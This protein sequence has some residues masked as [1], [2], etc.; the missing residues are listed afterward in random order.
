MFDPWPIYSRYPYQFK[1]LEDLHL[2]ERI[3]QFLQICNHNCSLKRIS[4]ARYRTFLIVINFSILLSPNYAENGWN[5]S[6]IKIDE[7]PLIWSNTCYLNQLLFFPFVIVSIEHLH[8]Y[9]KNQWNCLET[10]MA[11]SYLTQY[12]LCRLL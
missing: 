1:G 6:V 10:K 5:I 9:S 12:C 8:S 2:D 7:S 3:K 4:K 11:I